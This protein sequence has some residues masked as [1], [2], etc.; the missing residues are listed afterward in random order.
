MSEK[1]TMWVLLGVVAFLLFKD[2]LFPS[3]SPSI[4]A[5]GSKQ[6]S[7]P[8]MT[9]IYGPSPSGNT[10]ANTP[11]G[12]VSPGPQSPPPKNFW[13]VVSTGI[14]TAGAAYDTYSIYN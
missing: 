12:T 1:T 14:T 3:A 6:A 9:P 2:R 11:P 5:T 7:T 4:V 10:Y 13:D 8:G